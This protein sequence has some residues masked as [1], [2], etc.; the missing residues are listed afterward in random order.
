MDP[1]DLEFW[2]LTWNFVA[3]EIDHSAEGMSHDDGQWRRR[4]KPL[5]MSPRCAPAGEMAS[6]AICWV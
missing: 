1:D 5:T 3:N 4:F 2:E 6:C